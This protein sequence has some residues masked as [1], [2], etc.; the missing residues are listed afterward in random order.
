MNLLELRK[1]LTQISLRHARK[2]GKRYFSN[3][4]YEGGKQVTEIQ[5]PVPW[6]H[7]SGK[8]WGRTDRKPLLGLHGWQD[9]AGTFDRL[10][11]LL[12]EDVSVLAVDLPGHGLS[13]WYPSSIYYNTQ[14]GL[15]CVRMIVKHFKW[16][17]VSILGHSMGSELGFLY[18]AVYPDDIKILI[19]LDLI[20][21]ISVDQ[22]KLAKR[23]ASIIDKTLDMHDIN[24]DNCPKYEYSELVERL[25][26]GYKGSLTKDC[27]EVLLKRGKVKFDNCKY[28]YTRDPRLNSSTGL[29]S[30]FP[31]DHLMTLANR[32]RCEV[33]NIKGKPGKDFEDQKHY[34]EALDLV[35]N[36]AKRY[37]FHEVDG[38]HHFHLSNPVP[39]ADIIEKFLCSTIILYG[40]PSAFL[41]TIFVHSAYLSTLSV[42]ADGFLGCWQLAALAKLLYLHLSNDSRTSRTTPLGVILGRIEF[43][44]SIRMTLHKLRKF[45]EQI[46]LRRIRMLGRHFSNGTFEGGK[47][48]TEI[49]IPVPWGH[50]SGKWWGRTDRKPL[51]GL[52]GWLDNAGTFD[53]LIPLL[54]K[55]ISVLAVDLPGHGLS[56]WFPSSVYYNIQQGLVCVRM[57]VKYFKWDSVSI[58]GHSLGSQIGFL[59]SAVYPDEIN[60]LIGLDMIKSI[61]IEPVRLGKRV[62]SV[63]DKTLDKHDIKK[64]SLRKYDYMELVE[65]LL[66]GYEG[67]LT[68]DCCEILLKRG[69]GTFD[70]AKFYYTRD[71]R[72]YSSTGLLSEFPHD[73]LMNL[74]SRIRCEVLNIKGKPGKDFEDPK[75][76]HE[77]LNMVKNSAI[78]FEFHEVD[79]LHHF[80]LSNPIPTADIIEKFLLKAT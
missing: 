13:S 2:I 7:I 40:F 8:W 21:P 54:P 64:E 77:A 47:Q 24:K 12:P 71:P 60:T 30:E 76:Y 25:L 14:Q 28:Y 17:S 20:K 10:M 67:S 39:T 68:K 57:I 69:K 9:N 73:H 44:I 63:I 23:A 41:H 61:S 78:R 49:K 62:S 19:G 79:G 15:V 37:E 34:Y 65:R 43:N 45:L 4:T 38:S 74:A 16:D 53:R 58:L 11:P 70:N 66:K 56:S 27:C 26:K 31:H 1:L 32:I 35:K 5:I 22:V 29:L 33:L 36:S 55:D 52:H 80:H 46:N 48:V 72:L 3:V 51:L 18:S 75:Y 50:I 42:L 59:Y 6:G